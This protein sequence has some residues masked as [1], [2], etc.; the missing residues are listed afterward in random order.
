M[1]GEP[2][3]NRDGSSFHGF[4]NEGIDDL[5]V[6]ASH[7]KYSYPNSPHPG[8]ESRACVIYGQAIFLDGDFNR[9]GVVNVAF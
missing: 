5:I 4:N 8:D 3:G 2:R 6:G 7:L 1:I 9:N